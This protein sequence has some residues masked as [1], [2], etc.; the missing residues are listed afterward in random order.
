M[1]AE[2]LVSQIFPRKSGIKPVLRDFAV[3]EFDIAQLIIY[4]IL[5]T[6]SK[7]ES[8]YNYEE[9]LRARVGRSLIG[10]IV[11]D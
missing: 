9:K 1:F 7:L 5:I 4:P 3:Y 10:S 6:F 2:L 11:L 8:V